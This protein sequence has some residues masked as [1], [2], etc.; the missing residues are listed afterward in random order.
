MPARRWRILLA[1][2]ASLV[3]APWFGMPSVRGA[4]QG[5]YPD[6]PIHMVVPFAAGTQLDLAARIIGPRLSD[7]LGQ[8][9][10]VENHPGASSTIG[11]KLVA[12]SAP[13]GYTLLLTGSLITQLPSTFGAGAVDPVTAF[14]PISKVGNVPLLILVHPS[15]GVNTLPELVALARR[16]PGKI[17]YATPGVGTTPHLAAASL[18]QEAGID[19][20]HVPYVN[21]G[22]ALREVL[23]GEPPVYFA[24]RGPI[25]GYVE[26]GQLKA[27]AVAGRTRMRTWPDIATVAELGYPAAAVDPWN[28][29]LAPAGTPPEI[30]ARLYRELAAIMAEPEV[31]G[32]FTQLG[33]E[34]V[35]T[36]PQE[37]SAE[38]REATGRW[39]AVAKAMGLK[40]K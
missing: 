2:S 13:D 21:T 26:G 12:D 25:D 36:T 22:A 23:T 6:R 9:V 33:M 8:P 18:A 37:F 7:A 4:P 32:R 11:T 5:T 15:L 34:P 31:Q 38:I 17:A 14:V 29:V 28:G 35:A 16:K 10:I 27:L 1:V 19:L 40:P 39:P 30:I 24:F 3:L 20:L